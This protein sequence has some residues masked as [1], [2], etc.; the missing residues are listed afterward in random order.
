MRRA[1]ALTGAALL[2]LSMFGCSSGGGDKADTIATDVQAAVGAATGVASA[3][4]TGKN[5]GESGSSL[6]G[7]VRLEGTGAD[8]VT[9]MRNAYTAMAPV[10]K[11]NEKSSILVE[12]RFTDSAGAAVSPTE[13]G[14]KETPY[15]YAIVDAFGG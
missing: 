7:T 10:L 15:S 9:G 3:A 6:Q 12:V 1:F 5:L 14:L 11:D 2:T 4:I 8:A 13:V